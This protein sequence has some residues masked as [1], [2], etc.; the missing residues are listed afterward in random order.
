MRLFRGIRHTLL[1]E[2][3]IK[4]YFFYAIGEIALVVIGILI[5]LQINNWNDNR[6]KRKSEV[7]SYVNIKNRI[8]EDK[9]DVQ[10]NMNYNSRYMAQFEYAVEII[11]NNDFSK[12]DTLGAIATNLIRYS[13]FNKQGNIYETL[14]NSGEIKLLGNAQI[15]ESIRELEEK[16]MYMNRMENIHYDVM[17]NYVAM[18]ISTNLKFSTGEVK[19]QENLYSFKFQNLILL[20]VEIMKE[21]EMVYRSVIDEI[22][23]VTRLI[24]E[25]LEPAKKK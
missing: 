8:S 14:V 23:E 17:I 24:D 20:L 16:Y 21:K 9:N 5:A 19:S 15:V 2:K 12:L 4:K 7:N 11:D 13:D 1:S 22:D 10:G 6:I 18:I 3:K 25:E